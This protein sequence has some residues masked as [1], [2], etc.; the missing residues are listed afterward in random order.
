MPDDLIQGTPAWH[1]WRNQGIGASDAPAILGVSPWMTIYQLWELKTGRRAPFAGNA[2]TRRGSEMEAQARAAYEAHTGIIVQPHCRT[3]PE[4]DWMRASLDGIDLDGRLILEVK[5]PGKEDHATAIQG[6][7]P[8]KYIPQ[9]Q[10]QLAVSGAELCHYWSYDG[11]MGILVEVRPDEDY[12]RA[13]IE[14]EIAF[15]HCVQTDTPPPLCPRDKRVREDPEWEAIAL[16]WR[17][18]KAAVEHAQT[19]EKVARAA[20]MELAD[21]DCTEG[22]GVR[23]RRS[24]R[25]GNVDYAKVPE[26]QG[27]DLEAYR[28][29]GSTVTTIEECE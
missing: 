7:V 17:A 5:C 2:A 16:S 10:H 13:L 18:A 4:L 6:K 23:V 20:L 19:L 25:K 15:W 11:D 1:A 28:K 8:E 22:A 27:V 9:V 21:A 3:H 24:Y 14:A 12:I 26:L 29:K